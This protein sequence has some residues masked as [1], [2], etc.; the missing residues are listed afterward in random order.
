MPTFK[1]R[2]NEEK[3]AWSAKGK[4]AK[5]VG[6]A[7]QRVNGTVYYALCC[8]RTRTSVAKCDNNEFV[9]KATASLNEF[10]ASIL[11]CTTR[12]DELVR[13]AMG[14]V[15][16]EEH[17]SQLYDA[18]MKINEEIESYQEYYCQHCPPVQWFPGEDIGMG[19]NVVA[20]LLL[21]RFN[22]AVTHHDDEEIEQGERIFIQKMREL[23]RQDNTIAMGLFMLL[24]VHIGRNDD[25]LF[26]DVETGEFDAIFNSALAR[27]ADAGLPFDGGVIVRILKY[28][29]YDD[30][31]L[32]VLQAL[33]LRS[34][35]VATYLQLGDE[36]RTPDDPAYKVRLLRAILEYPTLETESFKGPLSNVV[37]SLLRSDGLQQDEVVALG[38]SVIAMVN[39][40]FT[41]ATS[42]NPIGRCPSE[43]DRWFG[44]KDAPTPTSD[45]DNAIMILLAF[46][47]WSTIHVP[48][49]IIMRIRSMMRTSVAARVYVLAT[50]SDDAIFRSMMKDPRLAEQPMH[51]EPFITHD[52]ESVRAKYLRAIGQ[53]NPAL[54][55]ALFTTKEY[56]VQRS[57][58]HIQWKL[59]AARQF[60]VELG[61]MSMLATEEH[62]LEIARAMEWSEYMDPSLHFLMSEN[63]SFLDALFRSKQFVHWL[64]LMG[65]PFDVTAMMMLWDRST[66]S[67]W[68]PLMFPEFKDDANITF[69]CAL[70]DNMEGKC[71]VFN[72]VDGTGARQHHTNATS[73]TIPVKNLVSI[74][75]LFATRFS[76]SSKRQWT[77]IDLTSD[78]PGNVRVFNIFKLL[79]QQGS[80]SNVGFYSLYELFAV[81]KAL[82]YYEMPT[83]IPLVEYQGEPAAAMKDEFGSP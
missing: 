16:N 73:T 74:S 78:F 35:N 64:K 20:Q 42:A 41:T 72:T 67:A 3:Q 60:R 22:G 57:L 53:L 71:V 46:V 43:F 54:T 55:Y 40:V 29:H 62:C 47:Q 51:F 39:R 9:E 58:A 13:S 37:V 15:Y 52:D 76:A 44:I 24:G 49:D 48:V 56:E 59:E 28:F 11:R 33:A 7:I 31:D 34:P 63:P 1:P 19:D 5:T 61:Y 6:A 2:T 23:L 77:K 50:T 10:E 32:N 12:R 75:G 4:L 30:P 27:I 36:L 70:Q 17:W 68:Y 21:A 18:T 8:A 45:L 38:P 79:I 14:D 25:D 26:T 65:K 82:D 69:A 80:L 66:W 83:F 81:I